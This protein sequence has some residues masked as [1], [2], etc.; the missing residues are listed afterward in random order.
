M[1]THTM[2]ITEEALSGLA[3]IASRQ[4]V[5][6]IGVDDAPEG[7]YPDIYGPMPQTE[8]QAMVD[9]ANEAIAAHKKE[10]GDKAEPYGEVKVACYQ[11]RPT[12]RATKALDNWLYDPEFHAEG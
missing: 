11:I 8:A 9:E 3:E 4:Y 5:V 1:T 12:V 10:Y 6:L 7:Q 2:H